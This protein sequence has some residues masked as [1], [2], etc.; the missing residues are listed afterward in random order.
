MPAIKGLVEGSEASVEIQ[1]YNLSDGLVT[2]LSSASSVAL[3]WRIDGG[4]VVTGTP[5]PTITDAANGV[6]T[7]N[8]S[9]SDWTPGSI[10][11]TCEWVDGS[12]KRHPCEKIYGEIQQRY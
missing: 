9:T 2:D 7:Y 1:L 3:S 4:A 5:V 6:I 10:V 8:P 12:G 11:L